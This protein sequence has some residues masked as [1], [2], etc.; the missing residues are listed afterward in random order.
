MLRAVSCTQKADVWLA[1]DER[2]RATQTHCSSV[3]QEHEQ[4]AEE[5]LKHWPLNSITT[6]TMKHWYGFAYIHG[7]DLFMGK[8]LERGRLMPTYL[9]MIHVRPRNLALCPCHSAQHS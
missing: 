2:L 3:A 9:Y 7:N 6:E 1:D 5:Y 4:L 8:E